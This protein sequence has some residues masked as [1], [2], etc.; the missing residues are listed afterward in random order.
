MGGRGTHITCKVTLTALSH[1]G[2]HRAACKSTEKGSGGP[3]FYSALGVPG[4]YRCARAGRTKV[5]PGG[6][7][8]AARLALCSHATAARSGAAGGGEKSTR[9][10]KMRARSPEAAAANDTARISCSWRYWNHPAALPDVNVGAK[11][12]KRKCVARWL[13]GAR[14]LCKGVAV[15]TQVRARAGAG[16]LAHLIL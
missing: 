4:L 1:F 11:N 16:G 15:A 5:L 6:Q 13:A 10:E 7:V 14:T 9:R 2:D 12:E 8:C 3:E